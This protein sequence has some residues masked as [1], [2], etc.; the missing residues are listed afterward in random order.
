MITNADDLNWMLSDIKK[1]SSEGVFFPIFQGE[2]VRSPALRTYKPG[3]KLQT[4][5]ILYNA[6]AKAISRS[7]IETQ[8]ILY[9]DGTEFM[10]GKPAPITSDWTDNSG[11]ILI[12][13]KLAVDSNMPPGDYVLQLVATDKKNGKNSETAASQT[14][15]FTVAEK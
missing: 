1:E 14:L 15:S 10:R 3:D 8:A 4:L 11:N 13:N 5:A 9:K 6:D 12:L 2:E 7:E